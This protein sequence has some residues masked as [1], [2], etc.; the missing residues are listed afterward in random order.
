MQSSPGNVTSHLLLLSDERHPNSPIRL[1]QIWGQE[2][3]PLDSVLLSFT[4]K[5]TVPAFKTKKGPFILAQER[6]I[7]GRAAFERSV[8]KGIR[9]FL[10]DACHFKGNLELN[11]MLLASSGLSV[12][13]IRRVGSGLTLLNKEESVDMRDYTCCAVVHS[14]F[15]GFRGITGYMSTSEFKSRARRGGEAVD[16]WR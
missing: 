7:G 15:G 9:A 4:T 16:V 2:D 14:G 1:V 11:D 13:A 3:P 5:K 10:K 8:L 6:P 12:Y